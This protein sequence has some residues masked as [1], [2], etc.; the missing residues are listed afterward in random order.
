MCIRDSLSVVCQVS[1]R[2]SEGFICPVVATQFFWSNTDVYKR[3]TLQWAQDQEQWSKYSQT[4]L[5]HCAQVLYNVTHMKT[6]VHSQVKS[7]KQIFTCVECFSINM[8]VHWSVCYSII[9][10]VCCSVNTCVY[11]SV[12]CTIHMCVHC[13]IQ[14]PYYSLQSL[15]FKQ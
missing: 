1:T 2:V 15:T 12:R 8:S 7:I 9:T 13:S 3:Q 11:L 4:N 6:A 5:Q 14:V 10:S